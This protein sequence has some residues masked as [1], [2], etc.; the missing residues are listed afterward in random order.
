[1]RGCRYLLQAFKF[2]VSHVTFGNKLVIHNVCAC[3]QEFA[4]RSCD[5]HSPCA[6]LYTGV[7]WGLYTGVCWAVMWWSFTVCRGLL[8]GHVMVIHSVFAG[9][10]WVVLWWSFTMCLHAYQV[11]HNV[12]VVTPNVRVCIRGFAG[13]SCD[14]H[15]QCV[16]VYA[17]ICWAVMWWSFTMCLCV[18]RDLL[19]GHVMVIHNVFVCMQGFAGWSCDGH[20]QCVCV[21]AGACWAVMWWS[22]TMCLCVCRDLLGGHV[23]V[24]HNVFVCMQGLA[25]R[26]C[27]G[28]SQRVCV[29][30]GACWAV[31]WWSF[32]MCLHVYRGHSQ[33]VWGH[34]QCA[35][36][37][38]QGVC[39]YMQGLAGRSRD[40]LLLQASGSGLEL[41][42][43]WAAVASQG[44]GR[45]PAASLQHLHRDPL[46]QGQCRP[47]L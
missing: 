10:C 30:A 11:I 17:G 34:S 29:Y 14:G 2:G 5:G 46:P 13:R 25:G 37:H 35:C 36:G 45:P 23:M 6:C 12:F 38:S 7:C 9:A 28:H 47:N 16:C 31:T 15:S 21:Y 4:G 1:M 40:G 18:C 42:Q 26:S 27:D 22:F 39:V 24:I 44:G 3:M 32:T 41:V 33:C 8:G 43:R 19:G 20:S